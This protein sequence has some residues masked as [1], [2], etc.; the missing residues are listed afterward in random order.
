MNAFNLLRYPALASQ[1]RRRDQ[2]GSFFAGLAAGCAVAW[3]VGQLA[4]QSAAQIQRERSLLQAQVTDHQAQWQSLQH[5]QARQKKWQSQA[6]HLAHVAQQHAAWQALHQALK[7]ASGPA[8]VQFLRLQ[9]EAETLEMHG[10]AAN[11]QHMDRAHQ[12]LTAAL[13]EHLEPVLVLSS[14]VF[15]SPMASTAGAPLT[16]PAALRSGPHTP[17]SDAALEFVWRS[18]WPVQRL[19]PTRGGPAQTAPSGQAKP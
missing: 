12:A 14:W 3:G 4:Q 6:A 17:Q 9:L 8:S 16:S 5:Q 11:A 7:E 15:A 19:A 1:R 13:A 10:S 2:S 18:G